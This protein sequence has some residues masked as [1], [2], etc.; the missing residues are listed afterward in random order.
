[1]FKEDGSLPLYSRETG[2]SHETAE[3]PATYFSDALS[4]D[5]IRKRMYAMQ[6]EGAILKGPRQE[7]TGDNLLDICDYSLFRISQLL[8]EPPHTLERDALEIILAEENITGAGGLRNSLIKAI[9][10]HAVGRKI[11]EERTSQERLPDYWTYDS[12]HQTYTPPKST[13]TLS[14]NTASW[15]QIKEL[16]LQVTIGEHPLDRAAVE[17]IFA[18][19]QELHAERK[20]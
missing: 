11:R 9:S 18:R 20:G 10:G 15:E 5:E 8:A 6:E 1:M 17:K 2:Q 19:L 7:Y 3:V 12:E 16:S 4:I 13:E 14:L